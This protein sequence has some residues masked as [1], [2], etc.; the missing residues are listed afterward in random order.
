M[1][2]LLFIFIFNSKKDCLQSFEGLSPSCIEPIKESSSILIIRDTVSMIQYTFKE[3]TRWYQLKERLTRVTIRASARVIVPNFARRSRHRSQFCPSVW[4]EIRKEKKTFLQHTK[5]LKILFFS[6]SGFYSSSRLFVVYIC[7][8]APL[9]N[10]RWFPGSVHC[11]GGNPLFS[12]RIGVYELFFNLKKKKK[13][14]NKFS[15]IFNNIL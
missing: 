3:S 12:N 8:G 9:P 15:I 6:L 10:L 7:L 4:R 1:G 2:L 14:E 13:G 5:L 11:H